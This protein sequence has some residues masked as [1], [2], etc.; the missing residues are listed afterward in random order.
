MS[1]CVHVAE[2]ELG[3]RFRLITRPSRWSLLHPSSSTKYC[4]QRVCMSVYLLV[5]L[6]VCLHILKTTRPNFLHMLYP[7]L[8][9]GMLLTAMMPC[10]PASVC[11]DNAVFLHN[12]ENRTK[13]RCMFR[14]VHQMT[15]LGAKSSF[16]FEKIKYFAMSFIPCP[17]LHL[18][19]KIHTQNWVVVRRHKSLVH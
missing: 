3:L 16:V 13:S 8:W 15:T 5:C 14:L 11:M 17:K 18:A 12:A 9:L 7:C 1:V 2:M 4:D 10:R 6:S 19:I